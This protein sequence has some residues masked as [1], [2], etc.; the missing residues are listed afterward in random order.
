MTQQGPP[1]GQQQAPQH[2][3]QAALHGPQPNDARYTPHGHA[4]PAPPSGPSAA[5]ATFWR[6]GLDPS[7]R[8]SRSEFWWATL[9]NFLVAVVLFVLHFIVLGAAA[10]SDG[11]VTGD[12]M[13][14]RPYLLA[15]VI[16]LG[17]F[18]LASWLPELMAAIRRLHDAN[19]SGWFVLLSGVPVF[20]P[21]IL[22]VL[23][24]LPP[25][26]LGARFDRPSE[27]VR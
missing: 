18:L 13:G 9:L 11:V 15:P 5:V 24:L 19:L 8:S 7:G 27:F 1:Y 2:W 12:E 14:E 26:V 22:I 17:L 10:G 4:Q 25:N 21:I 16:L 20:G 3:Q 6:R 23:T